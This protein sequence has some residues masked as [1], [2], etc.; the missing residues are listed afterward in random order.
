MTIEIP[1]RLRGIMMEKPRDGVRV[2]DIDMPFWSMVKFMVKWAIASIPALVLL[3]VIGVVVAGFSASL[4]STLKSGAAKSSGTSGSGLSA[5]SKPTTSTTPQWELTQ[6]K[7]PLDDSPTAIL[8]LEASSP[9]RTMLGG[10]PILILRC[11]S[12][13]VEAYI[14]WNSFL[15]T[16]ETQVTTRVGHEAAVT[17]VWTLSS[18]S[19]ASFYYGD[20]ADFIKP[21]MRADTL[22]AMT[23]PYNESPVTAIFAVTGLE[24]KL[25][26]LHDACAVK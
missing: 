24:P 11:T 23:T 3:M 22:I 19:R 2:V 7:N 26:T 8:S 14:N 25:H 18:D 13:K 4:L 16:S 17:R 6:S 20:V 15:G 21:L 9:A 12:K 1:A 5:T 10:A